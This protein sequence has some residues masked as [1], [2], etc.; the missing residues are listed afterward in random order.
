MNNVNNE[1]D[2]AAWDFL[3]NDLRRYGD[4]NADQRE[5]LDGT[6]AA[7][8]LNDPGSVEELFEALAPL[9]DGREKLISTLLQQVVQAWL[10]RDEEASL[11]P[12][13]VVRLVDWY[14][15]TE[16][17][18]ELRPVIL[19]TFAI[20]GSTRALAALADLIATQ[21][22]G[23]ERQA[24][25]ALVPLFQPRGDKVK[26]AAALFPRLL[27]ALADPKLAAAV[28]DLA[29]FLT[30]RG[31]VAEHPAKA[32]IAELATL[33]GNLGQRLARI[34]EAP[35]E[36]ATTP[37]ELSK[38]VNEAVTLVVA[39]CD[40][41]ALAG[42]PSVVGKL[43]PLLELAH[44]RVQAE[45]AAALARLGEKQ[46]I[47]HLKLL[48][49]QPAARTRVLAYLEELKALDQVDEQ[50]RTV[51]ARA[52]GDLAAWMAQP[53]R[54]GVAPDELELIDRAKQYWPGYVDPVDC[55]LFTYEYRHG[56]RSV[57]GVGIAGPTT[58]ALQIDL[59]DLPPSDIYALYAGLDAEHAEL[60]ETA[61]ED[62]TEQQLSAWEQVRDDLRTQG[63]GQVELYAWNHFFGEQHAVATAV[64]E[65]RPGVIIVGDDS[66]EWFGLT[67]TLRAFTPA[68]VYAMYKGRKLLKTFNKGD[69][70]GN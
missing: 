40:A 18:A 30:R 14:G 27:D 67:T 55:L 42:D 52:Q 9:C 28:I 24:V 43:L 7:L 33:L 68:E 57:A 13:T 64:H 15:V 49:A 59:Q 48:A 21:P 12:Q 70:P 22:P 23:E 25:L 8:E 35:Q 29:N 46:G 11:S 60:F 32:R 65:G 17:A 50:Y 37:V 10:H 31:F 26:G 44:R 6:V 16:T 20:D 53:T 34:E 56:D 54:F 5:A 51:E 2:D 58:S 69:A 45:S 19:R 66:A 36:Y 4:L 61:L 39:L 3:L 41:L 1:L 47:E 38:I 62:L 63:Y